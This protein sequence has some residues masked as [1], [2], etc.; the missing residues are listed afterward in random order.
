[1]D[2]RKMSLRMIQLPVIENT[3]VSLNDKQNA[4]V[5]Y[6]SYQKHLIAFNMIFV[7]INY[8]NMESGAYHIRQLNPILETEHNT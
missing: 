5:Y 8:I 3:G 7:W 2:L 6:Q 1:M 4:T